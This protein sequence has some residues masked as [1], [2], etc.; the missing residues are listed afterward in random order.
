MLKGAL[1]VHSTYSDGEFT[2]AELREIFLQAGCA[3]VCM[4]DHAQY[5]DERRL[6]DYVQECAALSGQ[7]FQIIAGLEYECE[8]R[9]HIL[10]YGARL[11]VDD[12]SPENVIQH[13]DNQGAIS[14]I[15]HP[16]D[17]FFP[18]IEQFKTLPQGIEIWNSKYDG[19]YAP[20]PGT[21]A[22]LQRL[23]ERKPGM[24]GFFGQ[25]LHWKRQFRN[26]FV[27]VN[28]DSNAPN[29]VLTALSHGAF[30]GIKDG[31]ELPSSG[32]VSAEVLAQFQVL[33]A[34]S[35]SVRSFFKSTKGILDRMGIS[36]PASLKAR[37]RGFF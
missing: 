29:A 33:Q 8:R 32:I 10:G 24:L 20:R 14:V 15:A 9:M 30:V 23:R 2:L 3:F 7:N 37:V 16:K 35:Q 5:F 22:L 27:Q 19:K 28:A 34:K 4:T 21:F 17:D 26:L 31:Q 18:W 12:Q 11:L 13:I 1:H 6:Q 36:I 25:D